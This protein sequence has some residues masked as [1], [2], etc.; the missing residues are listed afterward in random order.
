MG[1]TSAS[2]DRLPPVASPGPGVFQLS[3]PIWNCSRGFD[4]LLR[5]SSSNFNGAASRELLV[6]PPVASLRLHRVVFI[7]LHRIAGTAHE[8]QTT[9]SFTRLLIDLAN[10]ACPP[11][12]TDRRPITTT[13]HLRATTSS[14]V[15]DTTS[16]MLRLSNLPNRT[17]KAMHLPRI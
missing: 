13:N 10:L 16:N 9:R 3:L 14:R 5:C 15:E 7:D 1:S 6:F 12:R 8:T 17:I 4:A 2:L 11:C